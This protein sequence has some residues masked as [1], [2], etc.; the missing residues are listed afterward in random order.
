MKVCIYTLAAIAVLCGCQQKPAPQQD[1]RLGKIEERLTA[2]EAKLEEASRSRQAAPPLPA[3]TPARYT[4]KRG[5]A[6]TAVELSVVPQVLSVT[7]RVTEANNM[8]W[9]WSTIVAVANTSAAPATFDLSVQMLDKDGFP[10]E[11]YD[12]YGL[13]MAGM[14][15][16]RY[17]GFKMVMLP[18]G[19]SIRS[20]KAMTIVK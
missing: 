6:D 17:T 3:P 4:V 18:G 10:V 20:F 12:S 7:G 16:N 9:K 2:V 1:A 15:T 19:R 8:W 11:D 14:T 5:E 13:T